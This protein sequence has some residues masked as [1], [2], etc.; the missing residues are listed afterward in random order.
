MTIIPFRYPG[1]KNKMLPVL[2]EYLDPLIQHNSSF[3]D[4]FVGGG[5]V[6]LEIATRYP[7]INLYANDK[8]YWIYCFW[9]IVSDTD[10][11]KLYA[12]LDLID[13]QPNLDLFYKLRAEFT[14]DDIECAYRAVFFN[15]TTFSGI[16]SSGPI[17][18]K[19]QKSKYKIDCRYNAKK[20]KDKIVKCHKLLV[21]RTSVTNFDFSYLSEL[22]EENIP[23]YLDPPYFEAGKKLYPEYMV[24]EEHNNLQNIL[25]TRNNWVLSYDDCPQIRSLYQNNKIIDLSA[26]YCINGKKETWENKNELIILP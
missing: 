20:L 6:L 7:N 2:I 5:S 9:K 10:S 1:S 3:L 15:R 4:V 19:E 24:E 12:L 26:R 21:G 23:A 11:D 8:N 16:F 18:G 25:S 22:T 14:S 13:N 17:G